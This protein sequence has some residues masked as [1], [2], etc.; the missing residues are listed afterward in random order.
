MPKTRARDVFGDIGSQIKR[1]VSPKELLKDP[2][3][4]LKTRMNS[5]GRNEAFPGVGVTIRF[6]WIAPKIK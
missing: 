6:P 4:I 3:R 2:T 1:Q 5:R